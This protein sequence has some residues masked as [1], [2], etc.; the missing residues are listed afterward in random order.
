[1]D[2]RQLFKDIITLNLSAL[3]TRWGKLSAIL[4]R[5]VVAPAVAD[6]YKIPIIINNRN[7]VTHLQNLIAWLEKN[8]YTNIHIIDNDSSYPPLLDFYKV[9]KYPVHILRQ[10]VGHLALWKSGIIEK[11]EKGYYVY[12]DPDVIPAEDCPSDLVAHLLKVLQQHPEIEKAGPALK[13]DDL[14]DHY[15]E[16][17]RV[18]EWESQFWKN[19]VAPDL[20]DAGI[21]TTFALYRPYTNGYLWV[22]K[23]Y[24]TGGKYVARHMPWYDH[25]AAPTP[26]DQYYKANVSAGASHWIPNSK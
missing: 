10:N 11:F 4:K 22:Q 25:S 7:R 8:G 26:E 18:I 24:R 6:P 1:M 16:K 15:S 21:D 23:A 14:P 13:I 3:R 9:C 5:K 12:T 2:F 17:K 19:T 20:Y